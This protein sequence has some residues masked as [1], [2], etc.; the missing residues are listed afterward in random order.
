M[1]LQKKII[2]VTVFSI[3]MG[4]M[5]SAV[6]VYLRALYYPNG[7]DFPLAPIDQ[8]VAVTEI[9]REAATLIM[10]ISI[11]A[12]AGKNWY[13]KFAWFIFSFA[14]WDIFYYVFLKLL[15]DWPSSVFTWDILFLIPTVW[16]G[17]VLAPL[18][19]S[20]TMILL[21]LSV[22][23][24]GQLNERI[25]ISPVEWALLV[26]GS[27]VVIFSFT[28]DYASFVLERYPLSELMRLSSEKKL[29]EMSLNYIP[30]SFDWLV[31]G[32]GEILLLIAIGLFIRRFK[33][34]S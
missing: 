33:S 2:W 18:I 21:S 15:L 17:P 34:L 16:I 22:L 7:F 13:E 24:Y 23:Y 9:I 19:L 14:V 3:A 1:S 5:E 20:A 10:L 32:I 26:T 12:L 8:R 25:F 31:F 11:G 6:V 29:F 28:Y 27:L 4:F 30:V